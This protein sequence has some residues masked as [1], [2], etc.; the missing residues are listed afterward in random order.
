TVYDRLLASPEVTHYRSVAWVRTR[1]YWQDAPA[2]QSLRANYLFVAQGATAERIVIVAD[3]LWAD[4]GREPVGPG[5]AWVVGQVLR[6]IRVPLV[7]ES[8]LEGE[9][10]LLADFGVYGDRA[11]GSQLVGAA[12]RTERFTLLFDPEAVRAAVDRWDRLS[13]YAVPVRPG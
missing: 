6:G 10:G 2:R 9:R 11:V 5:R 1:D 4:E 3:G 13:L 7:R 12:G 8:A